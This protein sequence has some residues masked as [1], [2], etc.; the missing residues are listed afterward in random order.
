MFGHM[1][2]S[3]SC[4]YQVLLIW[5]CLLFGNGDANSPPRFIV[6]GGSEIVVHLKE[7]PDTPIGK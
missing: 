1:A 2:Q 4:R 6:E 3:L 5:I 7:G